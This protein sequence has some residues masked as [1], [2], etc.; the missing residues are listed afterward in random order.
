[1]GW[2]KGRTMCSLPYFGMSCAAF[3]IFIYHAQLKEVIKCNHGY[4][5]KNNKQGEEVEEED[6]KRLRNSSGTA[7]LERKKGEHLL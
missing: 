2:K 7:K 3:L 4:K 1:M 6:K 5:G